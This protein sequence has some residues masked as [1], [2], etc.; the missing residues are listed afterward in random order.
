MLYLQLPDTSIECIDLARSA[1]QLHTPAAGRFIYQ[2][3]GLVRQE[4]VGN[5]AVGKD[6]R[7]NECAILNTHAVMYFI[8]LFQAAQDAN[9]V[10]DRWL[11]D[12]NGLETTLQSSIFLNVLAVLIQGGCANAVQFAP[13]Q[14]RFQHV[15]GVHGTFS[16][17]CSHEGMQFV[18]K[19][20]NAT[21][22]ARYL[23]EDGFQTF[24]KLASVL[25]SCDE[26]TQIEGHYLFVGQRFWHITAHDTLGQPFNNSGFADARL[27][28]Q[29]RIILGAATQYLD[30][31]P[32]LLIT[33]ND[34]IKLAL[35]GQFSEV[36]SILFK[37]LVFPFGILIGHAL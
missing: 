17:A 12:H 7:G 25:S 15:R 24:L 36:A 35:P 22:G 5:V 11:I 21:F 19:K 4:T 23:L 14:H 9:R 2:V 33:P 1:V 6:G 16:S 31:A 27:T 30:D 32:D 29:Y 13:C 8:A 28:N 26:C 34:R 10:L 37:R 20:D 18:N 3:D